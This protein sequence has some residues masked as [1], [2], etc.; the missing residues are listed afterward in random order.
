MYAVLILKLFVQILIIKYVGEV[1]DVKIH[2]D[3]T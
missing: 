1:S 2:L 3:V